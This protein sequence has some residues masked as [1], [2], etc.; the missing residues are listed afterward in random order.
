MWQQMVMD[1][2]NHGMKLREIAAVL[3]VGAGAV[4]DIGSGRT[5]EPK[6]D[7]G[8]A[9]AKLHKRVTARKRP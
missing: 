1:L 7:A 3:G 9:L 5:A 6:Y 8:V 2:R 4:H